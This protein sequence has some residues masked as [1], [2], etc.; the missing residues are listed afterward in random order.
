MTPRPR[1]LAIESSCDETSFACLESRQILTHHIASQIDLHAQ[2]GGVV[3]E[4]AARAHTEVILPL[5]RSSL[6]SD[7][8]PD[9]I[10]VTNRPGLVSALSVGVATAKTLALLWDIPLVGVHHIEGHILSP[11]SSADP[12]PLFPHLCLVVSGGHTELI[13]VQAPG[14]YEIVAETLDDAAGEAF[15][16]GARLLGLRYPGGK[17]LSDLAA[18]GNSKTYSLPVGVSKS[19]D[20]WSFS[21]LKTA[22]RRL[23][24]DT[25]DLNRADAAAALEAAIVRALIQKTAHWVNE[26]NPK[27]LSL[28]GGVAANRALRSACQAL[29]DQHRIPLAI[30][31]FER[32]TDNAAMIGLAAA[33]RLAT[34]Q[35]DDLSLRVSAQADLPRWAPE[36]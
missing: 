26:L 9:A 4:A 33:F 18:T 35:H 8:V 11:Y 29:A 30:P 3:P 28:V 12:E 20:R 2:W 15:D 24:D 6:P 25:A 34:G 27:A 13:H 21:G 1:I 17:A 22:M 5:L 16:K 19:P 36:V 31:P 23:V 10:A 14:H 7:F 32:C